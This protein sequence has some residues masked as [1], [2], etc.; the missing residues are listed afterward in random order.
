[1]TDPPPTPAPLAPRPNTHWSWGDNEWENAW[2]E[3]EDYVDDLWQLWQKRRGHIREG[4][5]LGVEHGTMAA[6]EGELQAQGY[7]VR[8]R[9]TDYFAEQD[10]RWQ[11]RA[12]GLPVEPYPR[13]ERPPIELQQFFR[14]HPDF[15]LPPDRPSLDDTLTLIERRLLAQPLAIAAAM[16]RLQANLVGAISSRDGAIAQRNTV[17]LF[18]WGI[19]GSL[20]LGLIVTPAV[21][22]TFRSTENSFL[23]H[24]F[25]THRDIARSWASTIFPQNLISGNAVN[26]IGT[27]IKNHLGHACS[28]TDI[29]RWRRK[30]D[31]TSQFH[32]AIDLQ[33]PQHSYVRDSN[34]KTHPHTHYLFA[35]FPGQVVVLQP[36]QTHGCGLTIR[37]ISQKGYFKAGKIHMAQFCHNHEAYQDGQ[38]V[39][40]GTLIGIAAAPSHTPEAGSGSG[41]HLH[42]SFADVTGGVASGKR[43]GLPVPLNLARVAIGGF[44]PTDVSVPKRDTLFPSQK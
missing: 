37:L 33:C 12:A 40:P 7:R 2:I 17:T 10:E 44:L 16:Q 3:F 26:K 20:T 11:R 6:A 34:G 43:Q 15:G 13:P 36:Q 29:R 4:E 5:V 19:V 31:G 38:W 21:K 24:A 1:M 42:L 30:S 28:V 41:P 25:Q 35:P 8:Q 22:M 18:L 14:D 9:V 39:Q 32:D 23:G 27:Q